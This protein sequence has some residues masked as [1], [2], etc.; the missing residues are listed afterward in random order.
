MAKFKAN[1]VRIEH[2]VVEYTVEADSEDEAYDKLWDVIN[3]GIEGEDGE[4]TDLDWDSGKV[5]H[6]EE[7]V[8]DLNTVVEVISNE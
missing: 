6:A 3:E 4:F 8:Q 5:V 2:T 1:L 7:M